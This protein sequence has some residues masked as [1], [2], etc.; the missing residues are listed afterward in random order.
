MNLTT[1]RAEPTACAGPGIALR[2]LYRQPTNEPEQE[3]RTM[4]DASSVHQ[5]QRDG[6]LDLSESEQFG[7]VLL[8]IGYETSIA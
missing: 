1:T 5:V 6:D 8:G 7:L 4:H 2:R 3:L